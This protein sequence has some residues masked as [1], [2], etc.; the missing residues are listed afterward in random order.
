MTFRIEEHPELLGTIMETMVSAV[1]VLDTHGDII[2]ANKQAEAVLGLKL[3]ELTSRKYNSPEWHILDFHGNK[4]PSENLPFQKVFQTGERLYNDGLTIAWPN[5]DRRYLNVNGAPIRGRDGNIKYC[6]F[7]VFDITESYLMSRALQAHRDQLEMIIN[8]VPAFVFFKDTHN[9][10]IRVNKAVADSRGV[11][12]E[13]MANT[14][15]ALYYPD[16]AAAYYQDDLEVIRT[17][18]PKTGIIEPIYAGGHGKRWFRTDKYPIFDNDGK[19]EGILVFAI[20]ITDMMS[21]QEQIAAHRDQL[22]LILDTVPAMVFFKDTKNNIISVNQAVAQAKGVT[23][24]AMAGTPTAQWYPD[25]A[26]KYYRDDLEVVTT[27]KPKTGIVELN[28]LGKKGKI[29]VKTD[30]YPVLDKNGKVESI[31]VFAQDITE[32]RNAQQRL[33]ES[34]AFFRS[35]FENA[36]M[37]VAIVSPRG[38]I[39]RVNSFYCRMLGYEEYELK[40]MSI[41]DITWREDLPATMQH[42]A[43]SNKFLPLDIEKRYV[44]KDGTIFWVRVT[45]NWIFDEDGAPLYSVGMV[46]DI[47]QIKITQRKLQENKNE[48]EDQMAMRTAELSAENTVRQ[49]VEDALRQSEKTLLIQKQELQQ[50][51]LALNEVLGQIEIEKKQMQDNI[52]ANVEDLLM[53]AIERLKRKGT[54]YDRKYLDLL[55]ENLKGLTSSFNRKLSIDQLK[56]TPKEIEI[57]NMI[58]K[59]MSTKEISQL[60]NLSMRTVENHRNHIRAK[61]GI[62]NKRLNLSTYLKSV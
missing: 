34:E 52:L 33:K 55:E 37:G 12:V 46:Q 20:D 11:T 32:Q 13:A 10:H 58:K 40:E 31:L 27:G 6:I 28:D 29:W 41:A 19:V 38:K 1:T 62:S 2:Y 47:D 61:L 15:C 9:N 60:L 39:L 53:P 8:T 48:L 59:G 23:P 26:D 30:K 42:F 36:A 57:C 25:E 16:E 17:Q 14:P 7:D 18:K 35:I 54:K 5:G 3:S 22:K 45:T 43:V 56:L 4:I 24:E 51:N 50:K 21:A 44:R 49:R